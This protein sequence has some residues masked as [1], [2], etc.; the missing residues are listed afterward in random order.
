MPELLLPLGHHPLIESLAFFAPVVVIVA[1]LAVMVIRD[2][3][4]DVG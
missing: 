4:L 1:V 2:R 3:R